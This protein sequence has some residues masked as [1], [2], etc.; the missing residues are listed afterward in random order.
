M[1]WGEFMFKDVFLKSTFKTVIFFVVYTLLFILFFATLKYTIP[2][3]LGFFISRLVMPFNKYLRRKLPFSKKISSVL[4]AL[5][6]TLLI[7]TVL[8]SVL[9]FSL[10]KIVNEI[11]MF[12]ESLP[13]IDTFIGY[14]ETITGDLD[15]YYDLFDLSK[16][17]L[18]L[19]K[20]FS[21][22]LSSIASSAINVTRY[23]MNKLVPIAIGLPMII[24]VGFITFL[25]TYYFSKDMP[26]IER[27]LLS[28]FTSEGRIQAK[29]ILRETK[30]MLFSYVKSYVYIMGLTF[31]ETLIGLNILGVNYSILLSIFTAIVD[32]LPVL[33][34]GSV[35]MPMAVYFYFKGETFVSIGLV[36]MFIIV[37]IIRQIAEPK[38]VSTSVG[39]HPLLI[40]ASLFIGLKSFGILG[41]I[42][43]ISIILFYKIFK[44]VE[45]L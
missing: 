2:F 32:L 44:K 13:D 16:F 24:A 28:I 26:N 27:K 29:R 18:N 5:I 37:T 7:I 14:I 19:A 15:K 40:I 12:I 3:V 21:T 23:I 31:I 25:S 4:S 17:D 43:F 42:Y 39:I 11:R 10:Y 35:Y 30:T 36:I 45:I 20:E 41:I 22:Q 34:V 8:V 6:S 33:G 38:V 9:S 1:N